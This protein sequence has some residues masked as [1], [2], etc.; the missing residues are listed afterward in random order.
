MSK[1]SPSE[2]ILL[3]QVWKQGQLSAKEIHEVCGDQLDWSF[4][5]TRTTLRRMVDKDLLG[6]EK[7][8][9]VTTFKARQSKVKT[10][11]GLMQDFM[12]R[13]LEMKGDIPTSAFTSSDV[14][15]A[16]ELAELKTILDE[17]KT[18]KDEEAPGS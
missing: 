8:H 10:M 2:L 3:K 6:I 7:V 4:S 12:S 15:S 5:S 13:V 17:N 9:G 11:A 18:S 16:E 1:I 14:L